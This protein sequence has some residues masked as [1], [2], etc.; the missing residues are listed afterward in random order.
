[1]TCRTQI[2][3]LLTNSGVFYQLFSLTYHFIFWTAPKLLQLQTVT[4]NF[5]KRTTLIDLK[6]DEQYYIKHPLE[7]NLGYYMLK[8]HVR[9]LFLVIFNETTF[10][11]GCMVS[12]RATTMYYQRTKN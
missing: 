10:F 3:K 7:G 5:V 8:C 12:A 1:M 4:I 6:P 2:T 9:L 11:N